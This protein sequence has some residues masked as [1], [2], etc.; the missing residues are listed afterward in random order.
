MEIYLDSRKKAE[1][2]LV[3]R[4][5]GAKIIDVTSKS[6]DEFVRF[7]PFYPHGGIPIP[8]SG[9]QTAQSVEGIWQG[10]KVFEGNDVD[11][12]CFQNT[13][14]KNLKRTVRKWGQPLGHR[15]GVNGQ[16]LLPYLE[17]RLQIYLPVYRWVLAHKLTTELTEKL[18]QWN[19]TQDL[20]L[21]DYETNGDV[22]N[23]SKPLSHAS[24]IKAYL[25]ES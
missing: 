5:P 11:T 1:Q 16:E 23:I 20:V 7:S 9:G 2:T 25:E 10:L 13:T 15:K 17:A 12:G 6:A 19:K 8:Y 4:Y 18:R 14:M 22:Y 21:L 24:L 3:K